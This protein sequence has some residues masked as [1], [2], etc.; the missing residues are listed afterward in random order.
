MDASKGR[1]LAVWA[2]VL[3][4]GVKADFRAFRLNSSASSTVIR[5]VVESWKAGTA[6]AG[7]CLRMCSLEMVWIRDAAA[8]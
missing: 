5:S 4:A 8:N 2:R 3:M 7:E 1:S 6:G